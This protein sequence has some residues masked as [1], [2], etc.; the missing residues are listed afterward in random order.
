[1]AA[2]WSL[3]SSSPAAC[4]RSSTISWR[5]GSTPSPPSPTR[6]PTQ[7]SPASNRR[8][9]ASVCEAPGCS[10]MMR[11]NSST[12]ASTAARWASGSRVVVSDIPVTSQTVEASGV[13]GEGGVA[14]VVGQV[15]LGE[16][17][18]LFEARV[19]GHLVRE[20]GGVEER[21]HPDAPH[22]VLGVGLAP[23]AADHHP[24]RAQQLEDIVVDVVVLEAQK[25]APLVERHVGLVGLLEPLEGE[26]QPRH[27]TFEE[28]DPQPGP[29]VPH[30][31]E[32]QAAQGDQLPERV[33]ERVHG[34]VDVHLV[35]AEAVVA[36]AVDRDDAAQPLGFLVQGPEL[37]P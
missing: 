22:H 35:E 9:R 6:F 13:A 31:V 33:A 23:L 4:S 3:T 27:A 8:S 2:R 25:L 7:A 15:E 34:R 24:A 11:M 5:S 12:A 28:A 20:V 29:A 19:A 1:W 18:E 32:E 36:A 26:Q 10:F 30:A 37:L 14:L 16:L 21:A 17:L